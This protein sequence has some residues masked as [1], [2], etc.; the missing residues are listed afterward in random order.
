M[1]D[2][3]SLEMRGDVALVTIANPP[4]NAL[5][6][7]VR[8]GLVRRLNEAVE[9][10][11]KAAV[12][13]GSNGQFIAGADIREFG[14][15]LQEPGLPEVCAH[16]E[17]ASIPVVAAIE[18]NTLGGGLEVALGCHYRVASPGAKLGLPEVNLGLLPGAG[19]TQR[20][21]R[22]LDDV[23]QSVTMVSGG[24]PIGAEKAR[25]IGLVDAV[26]DD[27]IE[28]ALSHAAKVAGEDPAA[29]RLS[30]RKL[31]A[32]RDTEVAFEAAEA[33]VRRQAKGAD[34][35]LRALESV[36]NAYS[37]SFDE[38]MAEERRIF[39]E[40]VSS[41][42]SAALRHIFFAERQAAKAPDGVNGTPR[43]VE[44]VGVI[45]AGTM[46]G[47]IAMTYAQAGLSVT[48]LEMSDEALDRGFSTMEKNWSR[49]IRSGRITQEGVAE[50]MGRLT[51]T[52]SYDD[53][54]DCDLLIE[55]VFETMD[56]KRD[57]FGKLDKVAKKG[58]VLAS[59]TSYLDVNSIAA[60]TKRPGDVLGMHYFSPA[61]VMR[62]L[63]IVQGA[64]TDDDVLVTA[65]D[66][67]RR[68]GK[69]A[70][71][72]GVGHGFIGNRLLTP[73]IR[74]ANLLVLEGASPEQIDR[75]LERFGWAM[76][77]FAV[78]DLAGLDIGYKSRQD[79]E[80]D[81]VEASVYRFTDRIV[82][83]GFLG[84]KAGRGYYN[85]D[86]NRRRT[87]NPEALAIIEQVRRDHGFQP[88]PVSDEEIIE[89]TQF[90]LANEGAHVLEEGVAQRASDID[91][92]Y[93]HGYGYPRWRGG[94]MF[95]AERQG[96]N[97]VADKMGEWGSGS[98][99]MHWKPS[100]L[101]MEKAERGEGWDG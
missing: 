58:A 45:G 48:V 86:E 87:P 52:T 26:A 82:E 92:V 61:N 3:V 37:L 12:I 21:P 80:L 42:Q 75:A 14:L 5:S 17:A 13:A 91:V 60:Q 77:V 47:G 34:A 89:R 73:Y 54:A 98:G 38:G 32:D 9:G 51:R 99:G 22:L 1:P 31:K 56:V 11:A 8:E 94:P 72:A 27:A 81:P 28:G 96:L 62:L 67:A 93:V 24:R 19:G 40:L 46:G 25:E 85:Y 69:Q 68:T 50:N 20:L 95:Y 43:K 55:A 78:G 4:V 36:R 2:S 101:L 7:H 84:Q 59:N 100:R 44:K 33:Q 6:H 15:P 53:L 35:P 30:R 63:E 97:R 79:Q 57:V 71:V 39:S 66:M 16:I 23:T 18:G 88:R 90:A 74:Q 10:G 83:A 65:L 29:R 49:G 70:V 76:G 41:E 64:E